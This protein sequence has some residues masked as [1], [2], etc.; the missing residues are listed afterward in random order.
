MMMRQF[1]VAPQKVGYT[2]MLS[3]ISICVMGCPGNWGRYA[4]A[5]SGS[6]TIPGSRL[7]YC[8][9]LQ[10]DKMRDPKNPTKS[11]AERQPLFCVLWKATKAG[12][13]KYSGSNF[14]ISIHG[15]VISHTDAH[16]V[17]ALQSDYSL[18]E[19][20]LTTEETDRVFHLLQGPNDDSFQHDKTWNSRVAPCL[21]EMDAHG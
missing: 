9:E 21:V 8:Y 15:H 6:R 4:G 1:R 5:I 17:Y 12:D 7:Q 16:K 19:I 2:V 18:K 11:V 20:P 14:L 3:V 13:S 10:F